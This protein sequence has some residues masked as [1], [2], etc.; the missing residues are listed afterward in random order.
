MHYCRLS[1]K[2][3]RVHS[4]QQASARGGDAACDDFRIPVMD[5]ATGVAD[6]THAIAARG[7]PLNQPRTVIAAINYSV[8]A[9][10]SGMVLLYNRYLIK[11]SPQCIVCNSCVC[12]AGSVGSEHW[13]QD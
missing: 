2:S 1:E 10:L 9:G 11:I 6:I 3:A 4:L 7:R 13:H 5:G 12:M 8:I